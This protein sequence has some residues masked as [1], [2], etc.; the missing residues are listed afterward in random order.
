MVKIISWNIQRGRGPDGRCSIARTVADLRRIADADVLCLQEVS[1]GHTDM[2]GE[3]GANQFLL[4]AQRLPGYAPVAGIASD[5]L[6][7]AGSRRLFGNMILSRFP[8]LQVIRHAL[9]WPPDP[10]VMSM[11]RMALEVTLDTPMGMLRVLTTHLEYFSTAQRIAQVERVREL[12]REGAQHA[13]HPRPGPAT[14]GPFAAMPRGRAA[15]LA[16]DLNFAP[17]AHEYRRLIAPF[18]DGA[19]SWR[20][21][22]TLAHGERANAPTACLHARP[23][24][25][26]E[27]FTSDYAF[28]SGE[29]SVRKME[30][31]RADFGPDHQPLLLELE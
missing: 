10:S 23:T 30:V 18:Y 8:V 14:A 4:L 27:P 31:D 24:R 15:V 19:A 3:D 28:V 11:Q 6:G 7:E 20:D 13:L 9:P 17:G 25:P 1:A 2:G 22:W 21:A 29:I 12:Q 16:G 5:T 26:A